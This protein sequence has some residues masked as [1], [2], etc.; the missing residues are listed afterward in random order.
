LAANW[1]T[2]AVT[3][4]TE[5]TQVFQAFDI[6]RYFTAQVTFYGVLGHFGTKRFDFLL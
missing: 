2:S 4:A 5:T 6:H 1:K 3:Y